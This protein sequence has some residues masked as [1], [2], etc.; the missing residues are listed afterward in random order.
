[1]TT[2]QI[3]DP[4]DLV[5]IVPYQLGFHP[6]RSL[7]V[8]GLRGTR[9]H[10]VQR[11]DLPPAQ[12][13][14]ATRGTVAVL[15]RHTVTSGCDGAVLVVY[16]DG[17][18]DG[19]AVAACAAKSLTVAGLALLGPIVVRAGRAYFSGPGDAPDGGV[20][21]PPEAQV[22]AIAEF[23]AVGRPPFQRLEDL[24]SLIHI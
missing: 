10:V 4:L 8:V 22:P 14:E 18:G 13:A 15:S 19:A 2:I 5:M 17:P 1:M 9:V 20:P 24:L 21:L 3:T 7:V 23:V 12:A 11:C 16:E 6:N